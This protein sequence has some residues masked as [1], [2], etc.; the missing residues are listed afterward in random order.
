MSLTEDEINEITKSVFLENQTLI[1]PDLIFVFGGTD[2]NLSKYAFEKYNEYGK[3][4]IL[5]S[6]GNKLSNRD[7]HPNWENGNNCEADIISSQLIEAGVEVSKILKENE[8]TNSLENVIKSIEKFD[9][10]IYKRILLITR[11]HG[12]GRQIRTF[13]SHYPY[14]V[15]LGVFSF[16]GVT[17]HENEVLK[18]SNS[19]W[20]EH[21]KTREKIINEY[22]KIIIYSS[23]GDFEFERNPILRIYE[24]LKQENKI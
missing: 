23:K 14:E 1:N 6:G 7:K 12:T 3:P 22:K 16:D 11:S 4:K 24:Q 19:N 9:L 17:N 2:P 15:K 13:K 18:L 21:K 8:S 20:T 10:K 5:V